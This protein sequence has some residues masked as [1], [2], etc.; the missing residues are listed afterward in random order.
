MGIQRKVVSKQ[1][2]IVAQ[3]CLQTLLFHAPHPLI[4]TFPEVTMVDQNG[5]SVFHDR[6]IDQRLTGRDPADYT[7]DLLAAFHLQSIGTVVLK[8][9]RSQLLV[10]Q[11]Q[12]VIALEHDTYRAMI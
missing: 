8:L 9:V 5:I 12:H 2:D 1:I 11:G 4:L 10:E 3:Q 6:R 7:A